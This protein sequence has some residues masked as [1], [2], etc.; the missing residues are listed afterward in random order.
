VLNEA[1]WEAMVSDPFPYQILSVAGER[2]PTA[3]ESD[4]YGVRVAK[5]EEMLKAGREQGLKE[6]DD[7]IT[8]VFT[9]LERP[10][11]TWDTDWQA[12]L[13]RAAAGEAPLF[14]AYFA[15]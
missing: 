4:C 7:L 3:F 11:R 13:Q 2:F 14:E 12:A 1:L 9:L 8:Y 10:A 5:I 15:A 6:R